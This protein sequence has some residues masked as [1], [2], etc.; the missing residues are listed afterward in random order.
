MEKSVIMI[1]YILSALS[2]VWVAGIFGMVA[3]III[4]K[5]I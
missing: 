3:Y 5:K 4:T 2:V 1:V